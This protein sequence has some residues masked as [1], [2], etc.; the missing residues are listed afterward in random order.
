MGIVSLIG[1]FVFPL[2]G[3]IFGHMALSA[4]KKNEADNRGMAL[5]GLIISY[6]YFALLFFAVIIFFALGFS[7]S[8][9]GTTY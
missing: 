6:A 8:T 2:M 3:V 5:A 4:A 1:A 9:T 7:A